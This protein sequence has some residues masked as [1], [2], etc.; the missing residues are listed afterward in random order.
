MT[1]AP[2]PNNLGVILRV[3]LYILIGWLSLL[4]IAPLMFWILGTRDTYFV[5]A[6]L[7]TFTAAALANAITVRIYE[8]GRLSDVGLGSSPTSTGEFLVGTG[9]AALAVM[10]ILVGAIS[11]GAAHFQRTTRSEHP[12]ASAAFVAIVLLFGAVGEEMLF[13]GYAFQLLIRKLGAFAT[14]LPAGIVFGLAHVNN[15]NATYIGIGNTMLWGILLGYAYYR[16]S[17]L[18][19]PIGLHFGWNVTIPMFG[20]N[21]SGFT[22]G[23]TGYT[24]EWRVGPWLS[25]GAYGP[26]GSVLATVIIVALFIAVHRLFPERNEGV[27]R[28]T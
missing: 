22:M 1:P 24:L 15:Q 27:E 3:S 17:A 9:I 13:H 4:F 6:A 7:T 21:L 11:A 20:V 10:V 5:V 8:R 19:L 26:E 18:W 16:T 12:A 28:L 2:A 25:G 14:I 23:V